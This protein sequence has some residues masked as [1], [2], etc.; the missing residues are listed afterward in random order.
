MMSFSPIPPDL[1]NVVP[2][3]IG[4]QEPKR[5][6]RQNLRR[7]N[8]T[9][10]FHDRPYSWG[11][12]IFRTVYTPESDEAFPQALER[13]KQRAHLYAVGE[14]A[15]KRLPNQNPLD[16]A[17]NEEL[18]RRFHCDVVEDAALLDGA[19]AEQVGTAFDAWVAAH[20]QPEGRGQGGQ[21]PGRFEFCV[22][23]DQQGI[24]H[25]LQMSP[26]PPT[27]RQAREE[28]DFYVKVVTFWQREAAEGGR[29]WLRVGIKDN[30][31]CLCVGIDDYDMYELGNPDPADGIQNWYGTYPFI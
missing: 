25:V 14:L 2:R 1:I 31:F 7:L 19:D 18:A 21:I 8:D 24:D 9:A 22:M 27:P 12:T 20:L 29:F 6:V 5:R 4:D 3:R 11:L 30:L 17:P 26:S 10:S 28:R 15:V 16:P 23:L 13:L